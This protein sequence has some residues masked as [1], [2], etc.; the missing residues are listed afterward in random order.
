[1]NPTQTAA[2]RER[3]GL[4]GCTGASRY[5][6]RDGAHGEG[7]GGDGDGEEQ[8]PRVGAPQVTPDLGRVFVAKQPPDQECGDEEPEQREPVFTHDGARSGRD[9]TT[10]SR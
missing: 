2:K 3:N 4:S 8:K 9:V 7:R 1:M 5:L 10:P 6:Q